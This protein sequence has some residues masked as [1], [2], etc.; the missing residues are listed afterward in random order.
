MRSR[1]RSLNFPNVEVFNFQRSGKDGVSINWHRVVI[2][3]A[4][5]M[6]AFD[7]LMR[8]DFGD[9]AQHLAFILRWMHNSNTR[10]AKT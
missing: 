10:D 1:G 3:S 6:N 7:R 9:V 2:S 5:G 4:K 8:S